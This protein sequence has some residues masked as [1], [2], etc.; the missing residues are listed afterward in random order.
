MWVFN[1]PTFETTRLFNYHRP[2]S[3]E[4]VYQQLVLRKSV[5]LVYVSLTFQSTGGKGLSFDKIIK[6]VR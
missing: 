3:R 5:R 6:W 1:T 2:V 4:I